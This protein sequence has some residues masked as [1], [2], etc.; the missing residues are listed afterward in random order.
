MARFHILS[1]D[2]VTVTA[3]VIL[4]SFFW[5]IPEEGL[6]GIKKQM[7]G[8]YT[9]SHH[10]RHP[11]SRVPFK[12]ARKGIKTEAQARRVLN[13]LVIKVEDKLRAQVVPR[14]GELVQD[15]YNSMLREKTLKTCEAYLQCLN[16]HTIAPW[17]DR[18]VDSITTDEIRTFIKVALSDK[19]SSHQKNMLHF[20]RI[21]LAHAVD[22]GQLKQ[23]P[24][25]NMKFKIGDK[26]RRVLT[27]EQAK[28]LLTKAKE[29]DW[30]WYPHVCMAIYTGMRNGELYALTWD[31]VNLESRTILVDTSWNKLDGFKSTK[32]GDDRVIEIAPPLVT[33][34][35]ELKLK[36]EDG[37]FVLPRIS[38]WDQGLQAT[39][40]RMFLTGLGISPVRFHDLRAT[41]ATIMLSKGV[42]PAKVMVMG[43]WKDIKTLM[44]YLRKAGIGIRGITDAFNLHDPSK[45]YGKVLKF[46]RS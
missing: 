21:T 3:K 42:E 36:S 2:A 6:M 28:I 24:T 46:E 43:G 39:A 40:L 44:V 35:K 13:E 45:D 9:V 7:D 15:S 32:T 41:W 29:F 5:L 34:L 1:L 4:Q 20:I 14:W 33:V 17:G 18:F 19:S 23:N 16:K 26:I 27:E 10:K 25:P 30:E 22:K 31:K 8:T 38:I 11:I 37:T 12:A